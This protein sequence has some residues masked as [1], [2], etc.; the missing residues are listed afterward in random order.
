[1]D[2][3]CPRPAPGPQTPWFCGSAVSERWAQAGVAGPILPLSKAS[4]NQAVRGLGLVL[5]VCIRAHI[6]V[7]YWPGWL[8]SCNRIRPVRLTRGHGSSSQG[9]PGHG[10]DKVG[11][12]CPCGDSAGSRKGAGREAPPPPPWSQGPEC[13]AWTGRTPTRGSARRACQLCPRSCCSL[14]RPSCF[15][16]LS[17]TSPTPCELL[18][19]AWFPPGE[20]SPWSPA[21]LHV[22]RPGVFPLSEAVSTPPSAG[23]APPE[24]CNHLLFSSVSTSSGF[25]CYTHVYSRM[26]RGQISQV[27]CC[28][29][30]A[31]PGSRSLCL[32]PDQLVTGSSLPGEKSRPGL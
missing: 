8:C 6:R 11:A 23:F 18:F 29:G 28:L 17:P 2:S 24:A 25:L 5:A 13:S 32:E 1:M 12:C 19:P 15:S 4:V 21:L 3:C 31:G 22:W 9:S 14:G 16:F 26:P 10:P 27:P 7:A 20:L 30:C